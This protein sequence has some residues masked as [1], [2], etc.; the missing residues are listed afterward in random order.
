MIANRMVGKAGA[1]PHHSQSPS[2]PIY[3]TAGRAALF[4]WP[5][6][7]GIVAGEQGYSRA[8]QP[9]HYRWSEIGQDNP[10]QDLHRRRLSGEKMLV[11]WVN[12]TK[13]C[14]VAS[15]QHESEQIAI[16]LSGKARWT[17]GTEG[18]AECYQVE[19]GG[20]E[21]MV[22]PSNFPHGVDALEDT[23]IIDVLSPPGAMGVDSQ[24][25]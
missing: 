2:S 19:T 1:Q 3:Q 24:R 4:V 21:V 9:K 20:G 7:S 23:E 5:L 14:H 18:T 10:I 6:E 22:L 8:V 15:H 13:G 25:E 17:L 16:V 12:L 11:A